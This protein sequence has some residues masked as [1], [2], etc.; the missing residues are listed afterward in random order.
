MAALKLQTVRGVK[1]LVGA[2]VVQKA[3]SFGT[4]I[5]LARILEPSNFGVFALAFVAIDGLGL[6]KSMGFDSALVQKKGN[7][8]K[9]ADTAFFIIPLLGVALFS[10]LYFAAP[11]IGSFLNSQ[12]VVSVV[13]ALGLI[14]VFN[15][16]G[17]VPHALLQ[18]KLEFSKIAYV[19]IISAV[20]YSV[21]SICLALLGFGVWSL[22]V[23]Y[24]TKTVI[25]MILMWYFAE[26]KPKLQID[27][28]IAFEMFRFG[29]FVFLSAL[30]YF[31]QRKFG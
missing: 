5:I 23:G 3:L 22:V 27:V 17:M 10:M 13:R 6:F 1:W 25:S 20:A 19:E 15:C 28:K 16:F 11:S 29:K 14:F 12:E 24:L 31:F 30:V 4:M 21:I 8:E 9:A 7:I 2:G 18:R 26:W